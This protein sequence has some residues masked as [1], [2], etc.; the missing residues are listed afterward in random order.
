M[1]YRERDIQE[2]SYGNLTTS[3]FATFV[4]NPIAANDPLVTTAPRLGPIEELF[5]KLLNFWSVDQR[6]GAILLG[7]GPQ[8]VSRID[9]ILNGVAYLTTRDEQDRIVELFQIRKILHA[10]FRNESIENAWLREPNEAL[11]NNVPLNLLLEGSME[12]LLRIRQFVE[13]IAGL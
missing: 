9:P 5:S 10:L 4:R 13:T 6:A 12:N 11:E 2:T 1:P 8:G 3:G 7:Y